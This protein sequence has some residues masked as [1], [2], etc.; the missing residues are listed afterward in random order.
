MPRPSFCSLLPLLLFAAV[1]ACS[2]QQ[3]KRAGQALVAG[4][5]DTLL[6]VPAARLAADA[7]STLAAG[8]ARQREARVDELNAAYADFLEQRH[9]PAPPRGEP[10]SPVIVGPPAAPDA[11]PY[12]PATTF[13]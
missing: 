12:I 11:A 13:R 7:G 6:G 2:G 3:V 5:V 8:S 4:T 1:A 10:L 9:S